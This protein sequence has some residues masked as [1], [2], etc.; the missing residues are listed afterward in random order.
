[1]TILIG[2]PYLATMTTPEDMANLADLTRSERLLVYLNTAA[3]LW[4]VFLLAW[5]AQRAGGDSLS[6]LGFTQ[7]GIADP[8]IALVF[9][10]ASNLILSGLAEIGIGLGLP[11][12]DDSVQAMLPRDNIER[13]AW[14]ILSIS[15]GICEESVFRGFLLLKGHSWLHRW[16]PAIVLS[17]LAFGVGHAYQGASGAALIGIYGVMFCLLRL[18]RG[19]LWPGVWAHIW[20]DLGAMGIAKWM[21]Q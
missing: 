16:T 8:F 10:L 18:W 17:S 5:T 20:Q 6:G 14:V 9:L 4:G 3:V 2:W 11:A 7:P 21:G 19:S 13:S 1:M 12:P 15:A